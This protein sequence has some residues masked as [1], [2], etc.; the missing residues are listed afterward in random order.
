MGCVHD[1]TR[2][3]DTRT[4]QAPTKRVCLAFELRLH[5]T[6]AMGIFMGDVVLSDV[7]VGLLDR[8]KPT[9]RDELAVIQQRIS[10]TINMTGRAAR[11]RSVQDAKYFALIAKDYIEIR[12]AF[13]QAVEQL[14]VVQQR[15][16]ELLAENRKLR[17]IKE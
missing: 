8:L 4:D 9:L 15:C 10:D 17:G 7:A 2:R 1:T 16:D 13:V 3:A 11:L 12:L 6:H 14:G 5:Y